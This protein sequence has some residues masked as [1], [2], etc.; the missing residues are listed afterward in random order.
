MESQ[1]G[2]FESLFD[3]T[4]THFITSK[5]IK[6]LYGL[7]IAIAALVTLFFIISAFAKSFWMG[8]LMLLIGGPIF[9]LL[10]VIY[11][12]ITLEII[13]VIFRISDY[14]AEIAKQG[15]SEAA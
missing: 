11:S 8:S 12:R 3:F 5:I 7:S 13:I 15:Q 9:F 10:S 6:F 4:F 2:F 1:R 14:A